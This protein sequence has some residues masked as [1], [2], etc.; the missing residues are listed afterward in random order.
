MVGAGCGAVVGCSVGAGGAM[1]VGAV[2]A[3]GRSVGVGSASSVQAVSRSMESTAI[4]KRP[5]P[6]AGR[7]PVFPSLP[8]TMS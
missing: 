1:A 4:A 5:R 6:K 2:V 7:R 8:Y 3:V